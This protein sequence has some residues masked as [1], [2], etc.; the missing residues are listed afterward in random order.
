MVLNQLIDIH[1]GSW[2]EERVHHDRIKVEEQWKGDA[3]SVPQLLDL[4]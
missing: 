3:P 1:C 2:E 4:L